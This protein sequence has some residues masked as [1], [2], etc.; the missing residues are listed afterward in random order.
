[1]LPPSLFPG[2]E[3]VPLS[4]FNDKATVTVDRPFMFLIRDKAKD[5]PLFLGKVMDPRTAET[6]KA[7]AHEEED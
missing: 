7:A 3:L 5:V 2:I 4:A 1:M 6:K